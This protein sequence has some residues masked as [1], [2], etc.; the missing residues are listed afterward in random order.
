MTTEHIAVPALV[1]NGVEIHDRN[2]NLNL[3]D[4]WR[5]SGSPSGRAPA[6]WLALTS[7][8]EFV[9]CIEAS[10]N[11]GI[12]G[13]TTKKGNGGGTYAHWQ[14]ALAYAKYLSPEFH[15]QCN[16]IIRE[17]MEGVRQ[18][19]AHLPLE[20]LEEI[21]RTDGISRMLAHKVTEQGKV[22]EEQ[23]RV[24]AVMGEALNAL[25]AIAQPVVPGVVIRH[26]RTAGAIL[27]TAGFSRC[28]MNL[29]RW[30][31]NRLDA[32]GCRVEG[33]VDTG[34]CRARLF[35]PDKAEAWLANGGRAAVEMKIAE[36]KGQGALAL[37]GRDVRQLVP[38][39]IREGMGA[40]FIDGVPVF[41][42]TN[43]FKFTD[44]GLAVVALRNGNCQAPIAVRHVRNV[45]GDYRP[46][47]GRTGVC[48]PEMEPVQG[49]GSPIPVEYMCVILGRVVE[50]QN[51]VRL[52]SATA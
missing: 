5:A 35:D 4:M 36:R 50:R 49:R 22:Q 45:T 39:D 52:P 19:G 13:I 1:F 31:A 8:K 32:A 51:V 28:P 47:N 23:S 2:E 10:Y 44:G 6:D 21:R 26:G 14:I 41:F 17:R 16:I 15:M 11:A 48:A 43:D 27:K 3:T 18:G 42:D 12:S 9:A 25:V 33:H 29:A 40:L 7:A 34:V 24:L 20:V 30:F 37:A 38:P 46:Y